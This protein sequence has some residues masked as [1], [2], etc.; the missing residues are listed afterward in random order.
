[1]EEPP[2]PPQQPRQQQQQQPQ[3]TSHFRRRRNNNFANSKNQALGKRDKSSAGRIDPKAVEICGLI[4]QKFDCY[5]TTSSCAGRCF[6]YQGRGVK[7]ITHDNNNSNNDHHHN[8]NNNNPL[9]LIQPQQHKQD[10]Q[11]QQHKQQQAQSHFVRYRVS[12][13]LI[14]DPHRYFDLSSLESD[15]SGGGDPIRLVGQYDHLVVAAAA[16]AQEQQ[17]YQNQEQRVEQESA[18]QEKEE[19][20]AVVAKTETDQET[21]RATIT[22][23]TSVTREE[24]EE[25]EHDDT[26]LPLVEATESCSM[27]KTSRRCIPQQQQ[28]PTVGGTVR[29]A[30]TDQSIWLRFEPFILHVAC[31][32]LPAA[33]ALMDAARPSFKNVGITTFGGSGRNGGSRSSPLGDHD[34][35]LSLSSSS[36]R[37]IVA[38]WGDEGLD[39]P[40]CMPNGR[41]LLLAGKH[42]NN[43]N[44]NNNDVDDDTEETSTTN[45][46]EQHKQRSDPLVT[47][48]LATLVNERH[49]R[50]WGK[51]NRFVQAVRNMPD[52]IPDDVLDDDEDDRE[53]EEEN[54]VESS[55]NNAVVVSSPLSHDYLLQQD[56][57]HHP[58]G[59]TTNNNNSGNTVRIPKSF[60]VVGDIAILHTLATTNDNDDEQ[61]KEEEERAIA[62]AILKRNKALRVVA[63]RESNLQGPERAPGEMGYRIL[64]GVSRSPLITTHCEYGIKCVVDL[65]HT[66][67]TPRMGQ[68]RLRICQQVARGEHV[69]VLFCGV[70]MDAMQIAGRTEALSITAIE[71]NDVAIQCAIRS[72]RMLERNKSVKCI[73]AADRLEIIHGNV[74][75]ILPT[76]PQ[77]YYD[78]IVAPRPKEE[79]VAGGDVITGMGNG[80]EFLR[81]LLPV[82]KSNGGECHWY[83][84]VTNHEYPTC[85]RTRHVLQMVCEQEFGLCIEILHVAHVGSVAMRQLR[86]CI[87][88]RIMNNNQQQEEEKTT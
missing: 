71:Q 56:H 37:L 27:M 73:G 24:E 76:L 25:E 49:E 75:D 8:N 52:T 50:N 33:A 70:G 21:T 2:P 6:L 80:I 16:A 17:R 11:P 5:Y 77:E 55:N 26:V 58:Q 1:M 72:K 32:S 48:W 74:L 63:V 53:E 57:D 82:L 36:S 28:H 79:E 9:P 66:F 60:D 39:M 83:D 68:E 44:N 64:A 13:D 87:T 30:T 7:S 84:F 19:E 46:Q 10:Q 31:R 45:K 81:A 12:H 3:A 47:D 38:I 29:T 54:L 85:H 22:T 88:F 43:N 86:V 34:S 20:Q 35:R 59:W 40:L 69:L 42:N 65:T 61:H 41:T 18:E 23:T 62:Q 4:N 15:P 51:I 78:R 67:F 14:R